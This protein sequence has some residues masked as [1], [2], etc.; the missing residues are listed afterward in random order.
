MRTILLAAAAL[1]AAGAAAA[2]TIDLGDPTLAIGGALTTTL[3]Q[4]APGDSQ[5]ASGPVAKGGVLF[6]TPVRHMRAGVLT[7]EVR[8]NRG[9]GRPT[10]VAAG[11]PVYAVVLNSS[12][13][14]QR[15]WCTPK[16]QAELEDDKRLATCLVGAGDN[17]VRIADGLGKLLATGVDFRGFGAPV[18]APMIDERLVDFGAPMML[19]LQFEGWRGSKL[20]ANLVFKAG[21]E[22]ATLRELTFERAENGSVLLDV[23]G[24]RVLVSPTADGGA[25]V[26]VLSAPTSI[27]N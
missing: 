22:T 21:Q 2:Q 12:R 8:G 19:G 6:A 1:F 17:E 14:P 25:Q 9:P 5:F 3:L 13:G 24:G 10:V 27:A 16:A 7:N 15:V 4:R 11:T 18:A 26:T 20:E 23:V